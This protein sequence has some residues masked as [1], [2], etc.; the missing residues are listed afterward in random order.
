MFQSPRSGKFV[1]DLELGAGVDQDGVLLFQSPKSGEF[2]S[3]RKE[4]KMQIPKMDIFQSPRSGK[5]VSD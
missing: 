5:F 1:S 2:V 3:D 4:N